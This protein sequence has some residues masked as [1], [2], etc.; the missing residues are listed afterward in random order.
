VLALRDQFLPPN[1]HFE[2]LD[3]AWRLNIVANAARA[4]A[5]H[6]VI[7]NSFGFGGTNATI[8]LRKAE[9]S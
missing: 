1:I 2:E 6:C 9:A 8:V 3:P 7:S 5:V 4:A